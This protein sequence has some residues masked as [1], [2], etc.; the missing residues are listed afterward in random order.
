MPI[1]LDGTNGV[2]TPSIQNSG[3]NG[4]GNIGNSS[5]Y[6]NTVFAKATSAQY[7]DVAEKY[8]A[9]KNYP[10]GTVLEIGGRAEVRA[11]QQFASNRVCGVVSTNPALIMNSSLESEYVTTVALVGRVPCRVKGQI[12][13]GDLLCS[14][15]FPGVATALP[16]HR[17]SPGVVLGKSL[18]DYNSEQ[19]G[20][21]EVLIGRL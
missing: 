7:A 21:I 1:T 3:S 14:S 2:T 5:T 12:S 16:I 10:P 18:Q 20:I 13:K 4:T 6:F 8:T 17:Y 19:E 9:D 11:S 15:D